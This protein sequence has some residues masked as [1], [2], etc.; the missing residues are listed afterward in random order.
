MRIKKKK[1]LFILFLMNSSV[2][3]ASVKYRCH[4][5]MIAFRPDMS[6]IKIRRTNSS[7]P[8]VLNKYQLKIYRQLG[9]LSK[10]QSLYQ[11]TS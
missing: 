9:R 10:E 5:L 1:S 2:P 11:L 3:D 8:F 6:E 7:A 4:F